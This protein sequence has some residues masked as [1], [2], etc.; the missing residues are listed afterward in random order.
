M[1]AGSDAGH[2]ASRTDRRMNNAPNAT[3]STGRTVGIA[4]AS[5]MPLGTT[6]TGVVVVDN[7]A[8]ILAVNAAAEALFGIG[9]G[10]LIGQLASA[11]GPAFQDCIDEALNFGYATNREVDGGAASGGMLTVITTV[12][13]SSSGEVLCVLAVE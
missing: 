8:R 7:G 10:H 9:A 11:L 1:A 13:I 5:T 2:A 4:G 3:V 12:S 6:P